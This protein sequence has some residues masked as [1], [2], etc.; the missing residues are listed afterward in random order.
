MIDVSSK[1][2]TLR[3]ATATGLVRC[4]EATM[5][6]VRTDSLPKGNLLDVAKA[7]GLLAAKNTHNLI[8]HCHPVSIDHLEISFDLQDAGIAI[9]VFGKSIGRTGIE[10]EVL[11]AAS[12]AALT[13]Y[14]LLK[15]VDKA[16]SITDIRL[17][18]KT[19]GRSQY[20]KDA[21][22]GYRAAVLVCSDSTAAGEREDKSGLVIRE[23]L[24]S[25]GV[26]VHHYTILPDN[27]DEISRRVSEWARE[28]ID[29]I[30]TT[31]GTGAGPRD[32]TVE[33]IKMLLHKELPGVAEAMRDHGQMRTPRAMLSRSVAG[34]I[35]KSIV[36][37]LPGS[38][39][40]AR[41]GLDAVLP[42]LFHAHSMI[43][44]EGH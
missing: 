23:I 20:G 35:E 39:K 6:L 9:K 2:I 37:T 22:P 16:L 19:G 11:T 41:E 38:S 40:G 34:V 36:V 43:L 14:D 25:Y 15:P 44:G 31:G 28:G 33:A 21:K 13:I 3:T 17:L 4:T 26:D 42:G 18:E 7:A 12:V 24:E 30:F 8:P 32:V 10:M 27:L 1:Q 29:F 5:Q